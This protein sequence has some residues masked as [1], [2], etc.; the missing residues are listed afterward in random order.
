MGD[1]SYRLISHTPG[2]VLSVWM[3]LGVP[4]WAGTTGEDVAVV[5][6]ALFGPWNNDLKLGFLGGRSGGR[7]G[8]SSCVGGGSEGGM[9][10]S[11]VARVS[12]EAKTPS[13]RPLDDEA[14]VALS[15]SLL[16][17]TSS[18]VLGSSLAD[19]EW[20]EVDEDR[21]TTS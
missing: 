9:G 16:G 17:S 15:S 4:T 18:A 12:E 1:S 10:R 13:N 20:E 8:G 14:R 2:L 7:G 11:W 21:A 19:V 3:P 6:S 5:V